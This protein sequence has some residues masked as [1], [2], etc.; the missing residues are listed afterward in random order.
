MSQSDDE[1][2]CLDS[3]FPEPGRPPSPDPTT[4]VYKRTPRDQPGFNAGTS[5]QTISIRLVGN[6]P[7]W[8]HYLWNASRSF[9]SYLDAHP[10]LYRD[11]C[12]LEL[13][14]GGGLPSIVT[15]LNGARKVVVTDYPDAALVDNL[16]FN[17]KQNVPEDM[18]QAV[19]VKGY[20]W[21]QTVALLRESITRSDEAS[22]TGFDLII[23]SD[24]VFNH[25]QHDALL[26]TAESTLSNVSSDEHKATLLVFYTHHR[27]HLAHRDL[28]FFEKARQR[29]WIC[30]EI[31]TEKYPPMFPE[32]SGEEEVRA[33]V[34]GWA[35]TRA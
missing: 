18:M 21:G 33:T 9:A 13:G 20:I 5:W 3:I 17:V 23:M 11:R 14:A 31:V 16:S 28:E 24:L 12:V 4:A 8:G 10:E 25:S 35:L 32:D 7:L 30:E 34:H 19:D 29:G 1:P 27:P 15:A 6:H 22:S 2:L 26:T